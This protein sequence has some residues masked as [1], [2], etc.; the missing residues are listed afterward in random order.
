MIQ[1]PAIYALVK[2]PEAGL[3]KVRFGEGGEWT[4]SCV[5]QVQFQNINNNEVE[6]FRDSRVQVV[7]SPPE[8]I[9]GN[10]I[11]PYSPKN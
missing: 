3:G 1:K 9:S 6:T 10:F 5:V 7:V 8:Y 2:I 11:Y 4:E